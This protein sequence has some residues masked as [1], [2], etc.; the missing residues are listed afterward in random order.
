MS[1]NPKVIYN[2]SIARISKKCGVDMDFAEEML[3]KDL[4]RG[5]PSM[6]YCPRADFDIML[7]I[8]NKKHEMGD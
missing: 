3:K 8:Y 2:E 4:D 7:H 5:K 6:C 1:L